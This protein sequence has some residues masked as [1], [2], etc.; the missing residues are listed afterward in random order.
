MVFVIPSVILGAYI[1]NKYAA[2]YPEKSDGTNKIQNNERL[3]EKKE[4]TFPTE[5]LSKEMRIENDY[6]IPE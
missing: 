1:G 4:L 2:Y 3:C 5:E 6:I